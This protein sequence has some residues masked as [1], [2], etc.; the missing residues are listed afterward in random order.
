MRD[1]LFESH[2]HTRQSSFCG[3]VDARDVVRDYHRGGYDGIVVTDHMYRYLLDDPSMTR[4]QCLDYYLQG[5]RIARDEGDRIGLTVLLGMELTFRDHPWDFLIY[6]IDEAFL[7]HQEDLTRMSLDSFRELAA[8]N[9]LFIAVAHPFRSPQPPPVWF[10]DG[11]E[12]YNGNPRHD[13]SNHLAKAWAAEHGL[14]AM[15]GSDFHQEGDRSSGIR[16]KGLP[17]TS[18]AFAELLRSGGITDLLIPGRSD[19]GIGSCY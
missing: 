7:F 1:Y 2:L 8:G 6:G 12:I 19:R 11:V 15:A 17:D 9:D 18:L 14:I 10:V 4:R 3:L 16:L 13:S 5:Y